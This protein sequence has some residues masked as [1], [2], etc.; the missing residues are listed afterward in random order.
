[1]AAPG[2]CYN[3]RMRCPNCDTILSFTDHHSG[4][5][6]ELDGSMV[7][8][9]YYSCPKCGRVTHDWDDEYVWLPDI[10]YPQ[11]PF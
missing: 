1:M 4:W 7:V 8:K 10:Y 3:K 2:E 6:E 9:S 5:D 11:G